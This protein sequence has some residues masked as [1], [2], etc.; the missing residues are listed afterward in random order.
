MMLAEPFLLADRRL[1]T[2]WIFIGSLR[3]WNHC[4]NSLR[5]TLLQQHLNIF[6]RGIEV[7]TVWKL[8]S[9]CNT[10]RP[11]LI[12]GKFFNT[13]IKKFCKSNILKLRQGKVLHEN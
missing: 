3:T 1:K 4:P 6:N 10:M 8:S 11:K 7:L 5:S 2:F 13:L 9:K 12:R